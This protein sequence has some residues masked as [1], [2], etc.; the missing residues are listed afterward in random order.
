MRHCASTSS[1]D[2]GDDEDDDGGIGVDDEGG[3]EYDDDGNA[4]MI[5]C[6]LTSVLKGGPACNVGELCEL[7]DARNNA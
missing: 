4:L 2:D 5:P 1:V 7:D 3:G 6:R